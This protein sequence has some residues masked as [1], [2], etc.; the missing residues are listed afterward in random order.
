MRFSKILGEANFLIIAPLFDHNNEER[1]VTFQMLSETQ[2]MPYRAV[3]A[4]IGAPTYNLHTYEEQWPKKF[5]LTHFW[6]QISGEDRFSSSSSKVA[7]IIHACLRLAHQVQ[8]CTIFGHSEMGQ[9]SK[10]EIFFLWC[11]TRANSPFPDFAFYF[12]QKH[13]NVTIIDTGD[14]CIGGLITLIATQLPL[15]LHL[16]AIVEGPVSLN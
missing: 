10:W 2:I 1:I 4:L 15:K 11:M 6:K 5:H 16:F 3:N 12:F 9:I 7:L 13:Y 8:A 14:I